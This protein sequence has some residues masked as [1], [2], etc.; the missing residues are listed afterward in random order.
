[1]LEQAQ[2][3][4]VQ[5]AQCRSLAEQISFGPH[6][7]ALLDMAASYLAAA[8]RVDRPSSKTE[9][10]PAPNAPQLPSGTAAPDG[11]LTRG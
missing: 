2:R 9:G 4:L 8:A 7:Q 3:M 11:A 6:K 10:D 1:M 5:A